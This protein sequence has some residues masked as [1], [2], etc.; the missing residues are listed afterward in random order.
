M[1]VLNII[2]NTNLAGTEQASLRFMT[3]LLKDGYSFRV[4]SLNKAGMMKEIFESHG[5]VTY[6]MN[7][8]GKGG[9]KSYNTLKKK[10]DNI[11][12]SFKPDLIIQT[13]HNLLTTIALSSYEIPK[14]LAVHFHHT[15]IKSSWQWKWIYRLCNRQFERITFPSDFIREEAILL[16]PFIDK[17][18][19]TIRN[20][21]PPNDPVSREEKIAARN[22]L[23]IPVDALV[24]GNSSQL[25][26]RKRLDVFLET[27]KKILKNNENAYLVIAGDG[28]EK[29]NLEKLATDLDIA[30]KVI[31]LGWQRDLTPFYHSLDFLL[32][33]SDWD[34][35]PTTPLEA[36]SY[37]IPVVASAVNSG[38]NEAISHEKYGHIISKHDPDNLASYIVKVFNKELPNTGL[39]GRDRIMSLCNYDLCIASFKSL[40]ETV[41]SDQHDDSF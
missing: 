8:R 15:G 13:S 32:F 6:D 28:E 31:W 29:N 30:S 40:I 7:Y 27:G 12:T 2:P 26:K 23:S 41:I 37:G 24:I 5:I 16:A 38:L 39:A 9:W 22:K 34:A 14:V 36:M 4:L 20:P 33:N 25:I 21:L 19:H 3:G 35:F 11:I 1:R 18:S 10:L 17:K